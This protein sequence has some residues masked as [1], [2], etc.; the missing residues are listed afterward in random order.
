MTTFARV[1]LQDLRH[2]CRLNPAMAGA[3]VF[4]SGLLTGLA[5]ASL[6]RFGAPTA[7]SLG[8]ALCWRGANGW[9]VWWLYPMGLAWGALALAAPWQNYLALLPREECS[10]SIRGIVLSIPQERHNHTHFT[11]GLRAIDTGAGWQDCRGKLHVTV[12]DKNGSGSLRYGDKVEAAGAFM[13]PPLA[14]RRG[15]SSYGHYLLSRGIR[16]Q[17]VVGKMTR[18]AEASGWR[19]LDRSFRE[20]QTSLGE[21]LCHGI[22]NEIH[23]AMY[24]TMILGS[25]EL[26]REAR[27][28]FVRSGIVHVF[29]I[30]GMHVT[31]MTTVW[32]FILQ[33]LYL[34][35]RWRWPLLAPAII[36]YVLL[37]GAAPAAARSLW[38]GLAMIAAACSFRPQSATN[39]LGLS[40]WILLA[41]NPLDVYHSGFVFSFTIVAVLLHG[42]P[43]LSSAA[44]VALEKDLWSIRTPLGYVISG[45][46]YSLLGLLGACGLAWLGSSG[47]T[48]FY[49]GQLSWGG[50]PANLAL[51][52]L[53][54]LLMYLALP[55]IILTYCC[56]PLSCWLGAGLDRALGGLLLLAGCC[57]GPGLFQVVR[58]WSLP[59]TVG[60]YVALLLV[61][62][63]RRW[64]A[65]Q[66]ACCA[67]LA[68]CILV[69]STRR[70]PASPVLLCCQGDDGGAP[71]LCLL[72]AR[73][74]GVV[75]LYPGSRGSAHGLA[76]ALAREGI[77]TI[78]WL[79]IPPNARDRQGA[80]T[81][82]KLMTIRAAAI[83]PP[84]R[85]GS[86]ALRVVAA[87][88]AQ[89]VNCAMLSS[90][91]GRFA[92]TWADGAW[93]LYRKTGT[94]EEFNIRFEH[95]A[96]AFALDYSRS[97]YGLSQVRWSTQEQT[98]GWDM[99]PALLPQCRRIVVDGVGS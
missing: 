4:G 23:A 94:N 60:Y 27:D 50:M 91:H 12:P 81:I 6:W 56:P 2:Y 34:P 95:A 17:F 13:L 28:L 82:T 89:G 88:R 9:R 38:M 65:G 29:S 43:G 87:L 51:P 32:L 57:A 36:L 26:P 85:R 48:I 14:A 70:P 67:L 39:A 99:R 15:H 20:W 33:V 93:L 24:R 84:K 35:F 19:R 42:W 73:G 83:I 10:A 11:L 25:G 61:I 64:P 66:Y 8:L 55:K 3:I 47:L 5:P 16:R 46:K 54:A 49:N 58:S 21:R 71:A 62:G 1:L 53:T 72:S 96:T 52:P 80:L 98:G 22:D 59:V 31:L 44:S 41:A 45:K 77:A 79:L 40:A 74:D 69:S 18:W 90:K 78:D 75:V 63:A 97:R 37:T 92:V 68:A 7:L 76:D 30:S 86:A